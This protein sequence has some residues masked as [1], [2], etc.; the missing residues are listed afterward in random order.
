MPPQAPQGQP[1]PQNAPQRAPEANGGGFGGIGDFLQSIIA[2]QSAAR[3]TTAAWLQSQGLDPG[4]ATILASNK[5]ALQTYILQRSQGKKPIEIAGKLVDPNTYQVLADFSDPKAKYNFITGR[6]GS[7]FRADETEGS[8]SQVYGGKPDQPTDVQEYEYA[9]GQGYQGT[10]QQFQI[11]QKKAGASQVNID[12]KAEGA[13]DKKLA[14]NQATIFTEMATEGLNAKADLAVLGELEGLL[15]QT[16]GTLSGVSGALAKYGIG[17]A[18]MSDIQAAQALIN[19]LVP[20]QR[21]PGSGTMSDRDVELFTRSLP[22]LWN[23]PGGNQKILSVMRGLAQ[24]RQT[25]GEIATA[26]MNGQMSRQDAAKA[27]QSIPNP[28]A[29]FKASADQSKA[30][31]PIGETQAPGADIGPSRVYNPN[32]PVKDWKEWFKKGQ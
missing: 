28:L 6:D 29:G 11:E 15:G 24:Y 27:L 4:T 12:Q 26:V 17:G 32:P 31:P 23:A 20:T 14:E 25:Q 8:L 18:G 3:N 13:F 5:S 10:F 1:M 22:S 16:G 30:A 2:P 21:Q 19:K 7:I 9:K